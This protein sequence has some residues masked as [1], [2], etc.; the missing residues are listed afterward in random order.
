VALL[1][2]QPTHGWALADKLKPSGEI[3][4]VWSVARPTVYRSL[5][6]LKE[7]GLIEVVRLEP[8]ERGPYREVYRTTRRGRA[9]LKK[10]LAEPVARLSD[11]RSVFLLK[12]VLA[13]RAGIDRREMVQAQRAV[14]ASIV[15]D[16]EAKPPPTSDA[17]YLQIRFRLDSAQAV[18]RF[19]DDL[20]EAK[21]I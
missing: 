17:E 16:L 5:D 6:T 1:A 12:L 11:I 7:E 19:L 13:S 2:E 21:P 4:S 15:S 10:W 20:L 3:G 9:E 18:L 8:S 14:V